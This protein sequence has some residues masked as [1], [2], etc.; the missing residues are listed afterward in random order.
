MNYLDSLIYF[1]TFLIAGFL[2]PLIWWWGGLI[3]AP[4]LFLKWI[5]PIVV[6]ATVSAVLFWTFASA[7]LKLK[8]SW[9]LN[10]EKKYLKFTFIYLLGLC[11]WLSL[12]Y[13]IEKDFLKDVIYF[14]ILFV[15]FYWI[16]LSWGKLKVSKKVWEILSIPFMFCLWIYWSLI[17]AGLWILSTFVFMIFL[18]MWIKEA[19]GYRILNSLIWTG[20]VTAVHFYNWILDFELIWIWLIWS[21]L[22]G[23]FWAHFFIKL[24]EKILKKLFAFVVVLMVIL[25]YI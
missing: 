24:D 7:L 9:E 22:W 14:G 21:V 2:D 25:N 20:L 8:I 4:V 13:S 15:L 16:F 3:I 5:D 6:V 23:W 11:L 18:Q 1:W 12:V 19:T 10:I 17:W